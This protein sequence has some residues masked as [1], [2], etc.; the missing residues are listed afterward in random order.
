MKQDRYKVEF[1]MQIYDASLETL[2]GSLAGLC[3][4]LNLEQIGEAGGKSRIIKICLYTNN[5]H[6]IFDTCSE[7]GRLKSVKIDEEK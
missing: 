5:P 7:F 4:D 3:D 6:L 2:G 1:T